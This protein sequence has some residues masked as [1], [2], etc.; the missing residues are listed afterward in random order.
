MKLFDSDG[1]CIEIWFV[2]DY[3]KPI[4]AE[5]AYQGE[6]GETYTLTF[7]GYAYSNNGTVTDRVEL[8]AVGTCK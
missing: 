1:I 6:Y 5:F 2:S 3:V 7:A 4:L 8:S